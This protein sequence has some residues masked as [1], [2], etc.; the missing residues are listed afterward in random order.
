MLF[1]QAI[2]HTK[3]Q[4][5][6]AVIGNGSHAELAT[7]GLIPAPHHEE[8]SVSGILPIGQPL[9]MTGI[10]IGLQVVLFPPQPLGPEA[11]SHLIP[12][13]VRFQN[14]Q[15]ASQVAQP[16]TL[17]MDLLPAALL[18]G[19]GYLTLRPGYAAAQ[20]IPVQFLRLPDRRHL[21]LQGHPYPVEHP[22]RYPVPL[23]VSALQRDCP[24]SSRNIGEQLTPNPPKE[25]VGLAS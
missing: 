2:R 21:A 16:T 5:Q 25:G 15:T 7:P 14:C 12:G 23:Q 18:P 3:P 11:Q 1:G 6:S 9:L 22:R 20:G 19:I 24:P 4:G 17:L 13:Y 10:S 8:L